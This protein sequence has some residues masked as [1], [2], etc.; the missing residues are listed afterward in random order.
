[1]TVAVVLRVDGGADAKRYKRGTLAAMRAAE[2]KS[3]VAAPVSSL[4]G[5]TTREDPR[6]WRRPCAPGW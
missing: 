5:R 1:M 2:A 4:P 3:K 6:R